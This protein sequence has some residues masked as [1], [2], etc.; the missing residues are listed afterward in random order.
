VRNVSGYHFADNR[1]LPTFSYHMIERTKV[2]Q[3]E[4]LLRS[5]CAI[6]IRNTSLHG[7]PDIFRTSSR[8][9]TPDAPGPLLEPHLIVSCQVLL[10]HRNSPYDVDGTQEEAIRYNTKNP[11]QYP[12]VNAMRVDQLSSGSCISSRTSSGKNSCAKSSRL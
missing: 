6:T 8:T 10:I 2:F 5:T 4:E 11:P 1:Q 7:K 3:S 9:L 12:M